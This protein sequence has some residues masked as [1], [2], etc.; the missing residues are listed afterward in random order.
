[1]GS[2]GVRAGRR[3]RGRIAVDA[4]RLLP[5]LGESERLA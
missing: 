4:K 5:L 1:L 2:L 3:Q